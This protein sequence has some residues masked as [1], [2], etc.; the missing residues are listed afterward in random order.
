MAA[1]KSDPPHTPYDHSWIKVHPLKFSSNQHRCEVEVDSSK[2]LA[3]KTY[4]R[5][6]ILHSNGSEDSQVVELTVKTL[7]NCSK[8]CEVY[9]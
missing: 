4:E 3:K 2:L 5:Q 8:I 6:L 9:A 7:R 1:H